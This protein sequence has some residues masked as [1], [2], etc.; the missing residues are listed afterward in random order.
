MLQLSPSRILGHNQR[1]SFERD[2]RIRKVAQAELESLFD[3]ISRV[4]PAGQ[5]GTPEDAHNSGNI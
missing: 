4:I 3:D 5:D 1:M 2:Q